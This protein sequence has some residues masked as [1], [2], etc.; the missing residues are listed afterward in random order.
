MNYI[1][2]L[3]LSDGFNTILIYIDQLTKM[4]YFYFTTTNITA[5]DTT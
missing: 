3:P 4:T 2:E 1:V 5:E